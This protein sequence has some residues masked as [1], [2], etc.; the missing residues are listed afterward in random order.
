MRSTAGNRTGRNEWQDSRP[1]AFRFER[2]ERIRAFLL[3]GRNQSR[4]LRSQ[5]GE[6]LRLGH[7]SAIRPHDREVVCGE[8]VPDIDSRLI[9][10]LGPFIDRS[11]EIFRRLSGNADRPQPQQNECEHE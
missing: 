5:F 4:H 9:N 1:T 11:T 7:Q 10:G 8:A 2:P 3:H 6:A